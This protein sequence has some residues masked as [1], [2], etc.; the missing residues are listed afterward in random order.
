MNLALSLMIPPE[1]CNI[2]GQVYTVPEIDATTAQNPF[3]GLA[4]VLTNIFNFLINVVTG[5]NIAECLP[6]GF[7]IFYRT[8]ILVINFVVS[9]SVFTWIRSLLPV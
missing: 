1:I 8:L 2:E 5:N 7:D 3:T 9:I 6:S 4:Q